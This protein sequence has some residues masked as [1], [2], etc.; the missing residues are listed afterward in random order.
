[1]KVIV[2]ILLLLILGLYF[3][4]EPTKG[5][6]KVTGNAVVKVT[7]SIFNEVKDSQEFQDLKQNITNT[8]KT[9][10]TKLVKR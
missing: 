8:T 3:F 10:L 6:I 9:E 5:L 1:M 7:K 4:T 2:I